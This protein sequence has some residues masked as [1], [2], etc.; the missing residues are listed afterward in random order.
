[1]ALS[2]YE[3]RVL[4]EIET[5]LR[6]SSTHRLRTVRAFL[7]AHRCLILQVAV[8]VAM[9]VLLAFVAIGPVAAPIAAVAGGLAGYAIGARLRRTPR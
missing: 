2:E 5:E 8:A 4:Q 3:L 1:M 7:V 6:G 9:I